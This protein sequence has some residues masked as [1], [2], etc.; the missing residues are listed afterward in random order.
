M[1][2]CGAQGRF[3]TPRKIYIRDLQPINECPLM[4]WRAKVNGAIGTSSDICCL[5]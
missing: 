2:L 3:A 1:P 4:G 5:E